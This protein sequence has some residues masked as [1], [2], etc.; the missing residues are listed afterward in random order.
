MYIFLKKYNLFLYKYLTFIY[1]LY[2]KDILYATIVSLSNFSNR[3]KWL[4]IL[5]LK[6]NDIVFFFFFSAMHLQLCLLATPK[7]NV[8]ERK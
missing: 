3:R 4:S 8:G 2:H 6:A 7:E 5:P 1:L